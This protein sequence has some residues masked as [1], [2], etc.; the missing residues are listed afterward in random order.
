MRIEFLASEIK[1]GDI[2][3]QL[4]IEDLLDYVFE[5]A[6]PEEVKD[7]MARK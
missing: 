7:Y 3:E 2:F 6:T 4:T 5:Y 1:A